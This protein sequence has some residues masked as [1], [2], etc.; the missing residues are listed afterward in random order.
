MEL[1]LL[2]RIAKRLDDDN[3]L[4]MAV[5]TLDHMAQGG[6]Y[7]QLGGGFHRYST[8]DRWLAPHFEKMLYDNALLTLAY[9]E[10]YQVTKDEFYRET[11]ED[12][13]AYV[14]R[15]MTSPAGGFYS[16]QD[17]DSEGE[18]GKFFVWTVKEAEAILGPDDAKLFCGVYDVSGPGNWE[19]HNILH[20]SR[21]LEVEA[22]MLSL[23]ID[24][25][26]ARLK[27]CR[28]KL[29][30]VRSK[31]IWP[32][33]DEKILT[34]WN[35]LMIAA[36]AKA[37]QVLEKPEYAQAATRA[38]DFLLTTMRRPD[39]RLYRTT[40]SGATPKLNGYHDDY[41]YLVDALVTLYETT[42]EPRWIESAL[43]LTKVMVEQFW[44]EA[45]AGFFYT[46]KDHETLIAR[47]KDPHDNATPSGN[48]MAVCGLL[49]LAKLTGDADLMDKAM[50]TLHRFS[51]L[52]AGSAMAAGQMLIA[53]DF[54]LGPVKEIAVV[55]DAANSEVIDVLRQLRQPFRPH[56]VVAWKGNAADGALP[57]LK[58]RP[59][60]GVVTTYVCESF[61]CQAPIIGAKELRDTLS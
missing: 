40:F 22:K 29:F 44:D 17:A 56:Q 19:G 28:Q 39:G 37:A 43:S 11:V 7:D 38:A 15:E 2:L 50:R 16:T 36:F 53:L 26:K 21:N 1:R 55:G 35:A 20:L 14:L 8:D 12:T 51:G 27:V 13:L 59:A 31:R 18:E 49:R 30:D 4:Q 60:L 61:T 9:V 5:K 52:M 33:R 6:M 45:E 42:F 3:A 54:Q 41:A 10:A 23:P 34:S 48:A 47:T 58:D 25:L 46:G 57:L 24:T 32:G